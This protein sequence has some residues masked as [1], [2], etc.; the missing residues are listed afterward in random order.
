MNTLIVILGVA[1]VCF[2]FFYFYSSHRNFQLQMKNL[3][4][5]EVA[6]KAALLSG[7]PAQV[8]MWMTVHGPNVTPEIR[9]LMA[10][11]RAEMALHDEQLADVNDVTDDES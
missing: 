5:A 11:F 4:D 3:N 6:G 9:G 2:V 10:F 7:D 8:D 1:F